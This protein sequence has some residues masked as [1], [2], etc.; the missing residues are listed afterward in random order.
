MTPRP[1]RRVAPR[2]TL[3]PFLTLLAGCG[4]GGPEAGG[5]GSPLV[6]ERDTVGDTLV[7]RTVQGSGWGSDAVLVPE[8]TIGVLDGDADYMFGSIRSLAV[9]TDGTIYAM[10]GQIPALRVYGANGSHRGTW[11]RDGGGP[12]EFASPDGGLAVLAD[13][14]I[15]A[16]DPGNGRIQLYDA[17]GEPLTTWPV[18]PG[19]F[20]TSNAMVVG[21]GDTL[22]TPLVMDLTVDVAQWRTGLQR[23]SPA[24]EIVDT[25]PAPDVG[26]EAPRLEARVEGGTSIQ[27]LPFAPSEHWAWHPDGFFVHGISDSYS[28]TLLDRE[29]PL[30]VERAVELPRVT[31]GEKA[32]ERAESTRNLRYTDPNWR[33]DGPPIPDRKPAF[34]DLFVGRDGRIWVYRQGPGVEVD[35]PD[36]DPTDPESVE[37]R[38]RD[39]PLFDVFQRDGVFLG[40]VEAPLEMS[41][42][43]TPVFDRDHVWAITRD[44]LDVQ[45][46]VRYRIE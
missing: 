25:L 38:W 21:R 42:F 10:D 11:G 9:G 41:R 29:T 16:R 14:R 12:G 27:G 24:G 15:A 20:N 23:I 8:V 26:Y 37:D 28:F 7:V 1:R 3:L 30:R 45:R 17:S 13:G 5:S 43:P 4:E 33:W 36:Y 46:I 18:I 22:L 2:L 40:T 31:D 35:D 39:T 44:E 6:V 32:E 34:D 19:G